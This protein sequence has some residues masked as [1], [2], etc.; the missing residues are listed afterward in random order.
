MPTKKSQLTRQRLFDVSLKLF[1]QKGFEATTMREIAA[2]A[3]L[4]PGAA[5]YHVRSKEE[6]VF[7][8]YQRTFED[9]L[10]AAEKALS[11][12]T[13]LG[14]RLGELICAHLKASEPFWEI[15]RELMAT[16]I[17]PGSP[18]SP[19]SADSKPLRDANIALLSRALDGS[20]KLTSELQRSLPPLLWLFKMA[21]IF[22]W[23]YDESPRRQKSYA[24][25]RQASGLVARLLK[26][27][28]LPVLRGFA[29]ETLRTFETYKLF[30]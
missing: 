4:A 6:L 22:Y 10:P 15:S 14:Q 16:A 9:H 2:A 25:A 7:D 19:L 20:T 27:A 21:M 3:G 23:L 28:E 8:L 12:T 13:D 11:A 5:Y 26:L 1:R 17:L 18:I 30:N 29:A 24:L